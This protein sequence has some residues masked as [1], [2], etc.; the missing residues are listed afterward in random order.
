MIF[1]QVAD[2]F[3]RRWEHYIGQRVAVVVVVAAAPRW[4]LRLSGPLDALMLLYNLLE[5]TQEERESVCE[6]SFPA[7]QLTSL[8]PLMY[9][10]SFVPRP[11]S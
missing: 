3:H 10:S 2:V 5:T 9:S 8:K 1:T 4:L 11:H 6:T 7:T